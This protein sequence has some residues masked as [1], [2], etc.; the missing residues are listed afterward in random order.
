MGGP[1]RISGARLLERAEATLCMRGER[2]ISHNPAEAITAADAAV[3][4]RVLLRFMEEFG[5]REP[6]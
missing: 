1:E 6:Q 2:R 3:G 4:A 5:P